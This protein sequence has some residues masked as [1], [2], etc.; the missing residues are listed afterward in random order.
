MDAA[1]RLSALRPIN[2]AL[3]LLMASLP[4]GS[5]EYYA[6]RAAY[7][8]CRRAQGIVAAADRQRSDYGRPA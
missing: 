6:L 4:R 1:T 2:Q 7:E 3:D 8:A 5:D